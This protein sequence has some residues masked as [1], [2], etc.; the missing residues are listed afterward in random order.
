[1]NQRRH[2]L[3]PLSILLAT[4]LLV[5]GSLAA[6]PSPEAEAHATKAHTFHSVSYETIYYDPYDKSS[7]RGFWLALISLHPAFKAFPTL[8]QLLAYLGLG[9]AYSDMIQKPSKPS[10][11]YVIERATY[12]ADKAT[13]NYWGY[14]EVNI[15]NA[16]TKKKHYGKHKVIAKT[17]H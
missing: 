11:R 14:Y 13:A 5:S 8:Q 7:E 10:P 9:L 15:Y 12:K 6:F 2:P 1:M 3:K 4:L 17:A 16:Q